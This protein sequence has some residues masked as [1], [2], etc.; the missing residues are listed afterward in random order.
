MPLQIAGIA[1]P[2]VRCGAGAL[3]RHPH[4]TTVPVFFQSSDHADKVSEKTSEGF[5][6]SIG[7]VQFCVLVHA[8]NPVTVVACVLA[9]RRRARSAGLHRGCRRK[10][11]GDLA[12]SSRRRGGLSL[13]DGL[14][15]HADT[16]NRSAFE[17]RRVAVTNIAAELW[18]LQITR[19]IDDQRQRRQNPAASSLPANA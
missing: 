6:R 13:R 7:R 14:G 8:G 18:N 17:S 12:S 1:C 9:A 3:Y 11:V 4:L 15:R 19:R 2:A 10:R 5:V 16:V